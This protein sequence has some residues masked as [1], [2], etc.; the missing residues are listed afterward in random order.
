MTNNNKWWLGLVVGNMAY[1]FV[2]HSDF[3]HI[4]ISERNEAANHAVTRSFR[5]WQP[6]VALVS[7]IGAVVVLSIC[8]MYLQISDGNGTFGAVLG[9]VLGLIAV[10]RAI[11]IHGLD[12]YKEELTDS[13]KRTL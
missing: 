5:H 7:L 8:D 10:Q 9:F 1:S 13:T 3:L 4:P 2:N 11:F 6:W 12:Y